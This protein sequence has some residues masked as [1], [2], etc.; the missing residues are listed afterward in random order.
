M[1]KHHLLRIAGAAAMLL[2][3][4][5]AEAA[6]WIEVIHEPF[7]RSVSFDAD[8]LDWQS[9]VA[10][11]W[12]RYDQLRSAAGGT[13]SS[14]YLVQIACA[15]RQIRLSSVI[16]APAGQPPVGPTGILPN[17]YQTIEPRSLNDTLRGR[18]C[19]RQP[20]TPGSAAGS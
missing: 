10:T 3:P 9:D 7:V 15:S 17:M 4:L 2:W 12:V 13:S 5:Q 18:I 1:S 20:G 6:Q 19:R 11:A 14:R 16:A 8:S